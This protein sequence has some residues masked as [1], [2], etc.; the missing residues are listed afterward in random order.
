MFFHKNV[1]LIEVDGV[2]ITDV[3]ELLQAE[4]SK[5]SDTL[6]VRTDDLCLEADGRTLQVVFHE[7]GRIYIRGWGNIPGKV[8]NMN[9][10][11]AHGSIAFEEPD[12]CDI[13]YNQLDHSND[14]QRCHCNDIPEHP[15]RRHRGTK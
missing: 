7:E 8:G 5:T 14:N 11:G 10:F 2:P 13:C 4:L 12:T 6:Y 15:D 3:I 1:T 9:K